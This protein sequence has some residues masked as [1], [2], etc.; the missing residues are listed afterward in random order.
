MF[1]LTTLR[2]VRHIVYPSSPVP[3][4]LTALVYRLYMSL[5]PLILRLRGRCEPQ[6][7]V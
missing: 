5:T 1:T 2:W 3:K 7:E 4:P 6:W